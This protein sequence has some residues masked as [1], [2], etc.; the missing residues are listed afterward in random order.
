MVVNTGGVIGA[1]WLWGRCGGGTG[2]VAL[3]VGF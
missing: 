2:A 1:V 3:A